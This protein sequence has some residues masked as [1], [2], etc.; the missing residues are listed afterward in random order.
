MTITYHKYACRPRLHKVSWWALTF[1]STL[2]SYDPCRMLAELFVIL[3]ETLISL[4]VSG[5]ERLPN[6][7]RHMHAPHASTLARVELRSLQWLGSASK[8]PFVGTSV[9]VGDVLRPS[10]YIWY[11][12]TALRDRRSLVRN[13]ALR[14][15]LTSQNSLLNP[16]H[17]SLCPNVLRWP[18]CTA[19]DGA[20]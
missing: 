11:E 8:A 13:I 20:M 19:S 18:S 1:P 4:L 5:S 15:T 9:D 17:I 7:V 10:S 2:F 3:C 6:V 12:P 16:S 14:T